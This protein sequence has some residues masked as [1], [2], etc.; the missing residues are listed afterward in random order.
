MLQLI[1]RAP[2]EPAHARSWG[3]AA[4]R[5]TRRRK[6]AAAACSLASLLLFCGCEREARRFRDNP[7]EPKTGS[8][9]LSELHPGIIAPARE[10][11]RYDDEAWSV[12][13]GQRSFQW[14][15]CNGCHANGGGGMGPAL[16]DDTWIYGHEPANIFA[17]IVE[18]RPNG[19][20]SFRGRLTEQQV[21]QLVSYVRSLSGQLRKD[22]EPGRQDSMSGRP[23]P[24][25]TPPERPVNS[26]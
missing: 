10:R 26:E 12:S 3:R 15:N 16:M 23:A 4:A 5:R 1:E 22:V 11:G 8:V 21:W 9:S 18:G 7:P 20:P 14:F 13:E 19:M 2:G 25:S 17:S 24:Q 6:G